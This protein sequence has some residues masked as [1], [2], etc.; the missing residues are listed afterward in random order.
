[1]EDSHTVEIFIMSPIP[2][3]T[4]FY[5]P[6]LGHTVQYIKKVQY[7]IK[8]VINLALIFFIYVD[9]SITQIKPL[10]TK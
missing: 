8:R 10:I 1:M 5:I 3:A 2:E 7:V 6:D 4:L 9:P